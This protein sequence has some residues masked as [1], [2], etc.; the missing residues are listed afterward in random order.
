ML[1]PKQG[2]NGDNYC[3]FPWVETN[4][5]KIPNAGIGLFALQQFE[6]DMIAVYLC[7]PKVEDDDTCYAFKNW[8]P[9]HLNWNLDGT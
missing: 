2:R 9:L 8:N 4:E 1:G 7:H 5:S 6:G 3:H